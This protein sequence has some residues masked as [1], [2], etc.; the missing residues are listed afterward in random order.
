MK[1][2]H[3]TVLFVI[4]ALALIGVF[5]FAIQ[6]QAFLGEDFAFQQNGTLGTYQAVALSTMAFG[7]FSERHDLG[8]DYYADISY[9]NSFSSDAIDLQASKATGR[10]KGT[11]KATNNGPAFPT[12]KTAVVTKN[13][14]I[15]AANLQRLSI[16]FSEANALG[17]SG[18]VG[19]Y[20]G[21]SAL[22]LYTPDEAIPLWT[23]GR[24]GTF[25]N[26]PA[27]TSASGTLNIA[28]VSGNRFL[29]GL[30][31]ATTEIALK[32]NATY[33]I[34]AFGVVGPYDCAPKTGSASEQIKISGITLI[35]AASGG[36][37]LQAPI[38]APVSDSI[39]SITPKTFASEPLKAVSGIVA[40]TIQPKSDNTI[41][42]VGGIAFVVFVA[43]IA[44]VVSRKKR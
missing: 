26:T 7:N 9:R 31:N 10:T 19:A 12:V 5:I 13:A 34:A 39:D 18:D 32:E 21:Y 15:T 37:A 17:C 3:G 28:H 35:K 11:N 8:S 30:N 24:A 42:W 16:S 25:K 20:G 40:D 41:L 14:G 1:Q 38:Q 29:V 27:S 23:S 2:R 36:D 6:Q 22:Y 43:A 4:V 44:L 33:E